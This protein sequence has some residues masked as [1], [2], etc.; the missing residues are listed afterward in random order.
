MCNF[1]HFIDCALLSR[2]IFTK[3][4]RFEDFF[5][6][7]SSGC[8]KKTFF[9]DIV[10]TF[11]VKKEGFCFYFIKFYVVFHTYFTNISAYYAK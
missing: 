6:L 11:F 9:F 1:N 10:R 3:N 5:F 2:Y 7:H 4:M 8:P